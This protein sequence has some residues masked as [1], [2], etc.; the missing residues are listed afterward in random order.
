MLNNR[1]KIRNTANNHIKITAC[2]FKPWILTC[3]MS[4]K[5]LRTDELI[6]SKLEAFK[7]I[8]AT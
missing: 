7:L 4:K 5:N 1:L 2:F 8:H 3:S 6:H